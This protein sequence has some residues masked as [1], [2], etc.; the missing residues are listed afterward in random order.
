MFKPRALIVEDAAD[1]ADLL[2]RYARLVGCDTR[3]AATGE[4]ALRI[5]REFLPQVVLLDIGLPGMDGWQVARILRE[6]LVP[7]HPVLIAITAF[8][9][10]EDVRHSADVGIDHHLAKPAFRKPLMEL[11]MHLVGRENGTG[12]I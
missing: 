2:D 3:V 4:E 6:E 8:S 7:V 11:L 5:A 10:P 9:S 12:P 1:I